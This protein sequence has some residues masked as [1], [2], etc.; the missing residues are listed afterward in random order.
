M[1]V[2]TRVTDV[3]FDLISASRSGGTAAPCWS[4]A[5]GAGKDAAGAE[6]FGGVEIIM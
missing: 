1:H 4:S 2:V 6:T 3:V 5:R